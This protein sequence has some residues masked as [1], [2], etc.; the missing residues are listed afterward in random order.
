MVV[1]EAFGGARARAR[2]PAAG[3]PNRGRR[4]DICTSCT[5]SRTDR[6]SRTSRTSRT[7]VPAV[8]LVAIPTRTRRGN[9]AACSVKL[10]GR[11]MCNG[12]NGFSHDTN[13]FRRKVLLHTARFFAIGY[14][15]SSRPRPLQSAGRHVRFFTFCARRITCFKRRSPMFA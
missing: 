11:D 7:A 6:T 8:P 10:C 12:C 15:R 3:S 5:T 4:G 13:L 2:T 1:N 9:R 14:K